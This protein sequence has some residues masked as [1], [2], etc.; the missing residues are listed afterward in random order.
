LVWMFLRPF[1]IYSSSVF[2]SSFNLLLMGF[3]CLLSN[4]NR[5]YYS[6]LNSSAGF[7]LQTLYS[8]IVIFI[9]SS[10]YQKLRIFGTMSQNLL[11]L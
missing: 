7:F 3:K 9:T 6:F 4:P 8:T 11:P 1:V 2:I 5:L 10:R